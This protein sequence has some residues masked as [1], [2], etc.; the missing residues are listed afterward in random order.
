MTLH[1][2][3]LNDAKTKKMLKQNRRNLTEKRNFKSALK[4][5]FQDSKVNNAKKLD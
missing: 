1:R 3:I 2:K 4:K 5:L